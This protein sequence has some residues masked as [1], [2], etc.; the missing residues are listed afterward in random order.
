MACQWS[1]LNGVFNEQIYKMKEKDN[2][3]NKRNINE[4]NTH[5][6]K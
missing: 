6:N 2:K 1:G 4:M 5:E 3:L